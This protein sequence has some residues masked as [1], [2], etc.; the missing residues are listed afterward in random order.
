MLTEY[1]W[2]KLSAVISRDAGITECRVYLDGSASRIK[3]S[4]SF[5]RNRGELN[6]GK[7]T[8]LYQIERDQILRPY[9]NEVF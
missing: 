5:Q 4:I 3:R 9:R 7:L 1:N 8:Y 2:I 6:A